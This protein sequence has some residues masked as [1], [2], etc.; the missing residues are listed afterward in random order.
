M[1]AN[2]FRNQ[3]GSVLII[4][5]MTITILTLIC[6]TSLYIGTQ[7]TGSGMQTSGWQLAL[8]ATESGIDA[9]IRALNENSTSGS[10]AWTNWKTV[11]SA[12]PSSG[13]GYSYEPATGT[14]NSASALPTSSQYNYLPSSNLTVNFGN[15]EG[16]ASTAAWVTIDTAGASNLLSGGQQWYRIRSAGQ[17]IYPAN[18]TILSRV[19]NNRLDNDLRNT[20]AIHFNR[21]GGTALGPIRTIEVIVNP[22]PSGGSAK[23]ITLANWL[24]MS[25][26][27]TADAFSSA[28]GQW[29]LAARDSSNPLLVA[30]GA[31]SNN[32]KFENAN[33][34]YVYGGMVYSGSS[35]KNTATA[36][37]GQVSTPDNISIPSTSDPTQVNPNNISWT[38]TSPWSG[39]STSYAWTSNGGGGGSGTYP[40]A[41]GTYAKVTG[42]QPPKSGGN[43]I[44]SIA[45]NG[46]ASSPQLL[47]VNGDFTLGGGNSLA[48]TGSGYITVWVT[49]KLTISGSGY[50]TQAS[51]VNVT[52]IVDGDMTFSGNS[53]YG[54]GAS[55]SSGMSTSAASA[56]FIGVGNIKVTDSGQAGFTGT[57]DA[58]L[59]TGT[60]S[61]QGDF[62][63]S[64][65]ASNLTISGSGSFHYDESLNTGSNPGIGN[66][67]FASWFEDNSDPSRNARDISG[68]NHPIIY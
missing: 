55:G 49:G 23:G 41:A 60:I 25:G 28:N 21:N 40:P 1:K 10:N 34:T 57:I 51:G 17:T 30:Q 22:V 48:F 6:A 50:V 63:G 19:S 38:Y 29:S 5:L 68:T 27:G 16:A 14:G 11:S 37:A 67:A 58:P 65:I 9:A 43:P 24:E 36:V 56:N 20:I 62:T 35:P 59:A 39:A 33:Q 54:Y 46:T 45:V 31:T 61:G 7:N 8:T 32:G 4:A 13:A 52:W 44:T 18:S 53:A 26:S 2:S 64:I 12:L 47:V 15:T 66:Y 3:N 42:G